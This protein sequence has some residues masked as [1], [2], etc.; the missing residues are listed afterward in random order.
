ML[1]LNTLTLIQS[2]SRFISLF[3][4][5]IMFGFESEVSALFIDNYEHIR[6]HM[7]DFI[8]FV[9]AYLFVANE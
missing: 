8:N 7:W 4:V 2:V 1:S 6:Y 5:H 9:S 3:E